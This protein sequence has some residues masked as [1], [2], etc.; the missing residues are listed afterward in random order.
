MMKFS[1]KIYLIVYTL[2]VCVLGVGCLKV[3]GEEIK[4]GLPITQPFTVIYEDGS[5]SVY[6]GE[7]GISSYANIEHW[8]DSKKGIQENEYPM[9]FS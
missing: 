7:D 4:E 6:L 3:Y 9:S 8:A 1:K 5:E 2:L